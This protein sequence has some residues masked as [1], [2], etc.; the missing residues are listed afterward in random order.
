MAIFT[1]GAFAAKE[2]KQTTHGVNYF[3]QE[4]YSMSFTNLCG[5]LVTVKLYGYEGSNMW[6]VIGAMIK[7]GNEASELVCPV[8]S[9]IIE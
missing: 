7:A 5:Q 4:P 9:L 8:G 2:S 1:T 6:F 3:Y